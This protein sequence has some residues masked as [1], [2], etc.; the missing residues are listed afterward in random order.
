M[1][2]RVHWETKIGAIVSAVCAIAC[3]IIVSVPS[4]AFADDYASAE[5]ALQALNNMMVRVDE[6]NANYQAALDAQEEAEQKVA[7]AEA[8][9]EAKTAEIEE[10]Q[11][12]L[13]T[14][15]RAMYRMDNATIIDVVLGSASFDEFITNL[16]L[17]NDLNENDAQS[18]A[19]IKA[20]RDELEAAKAEYEEQSAIAAQKA[21]EAAALRDEANAM[22]SEIQA[23]Y[24]R[25]LADEQ[26]AALIAAQAQTRAGQTQMVQIQTADG[27]VEVP[28]GG[29]EQLIQYDAAT[30]ENYVPQDNIVAYDEAS[31]VATL[32]DG[33][34][35]QVVGYDSNTGNAIVDLAMSF[36][37]GNYSYG[38]ED[39]SS[40]TFDC[41]GL[42]Q[43]VY[44][45]NGIDVGG[46]NDRA[47]LNAGTVVDSGDAQ[48][49]DILWWDGH[50]AIYTGDGMMVSA[51]NEEYGITYRE[52]SDGATYVRY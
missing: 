27:W 26:T 2:E 8:T 42:V 20:A 48:A 14:R 34:T 6:A 37:G 18:V 33:T 10:L 47:I 28:Q 39:A 41:S 19:E 12:H 3:A 15:L 23:E 11:K 29:N 32:S 4:L 24:Q 7:E 52:V 25:L 40:S 22:A 44:S 5:A 31:G 1:F 50:V 21:E 51:D 16:D 13:C 35:A 9:I 45:Q 49:G 36:V 30:Q 17:L 43:Y 38:A 46:H